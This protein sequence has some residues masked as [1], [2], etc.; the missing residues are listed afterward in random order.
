MSEAY[1]RGIPGAIVLMHEK[2]K[3]QLIESLEERLGL[4]GNYKR[5][6]DEKKK[7]LSSDV[8]E[9]D[10]W[11]KELGEKQLPILE[12]YD[13]G[14]CLKN[15]SK[16]FAFLAE[17]L[18][19]LRAS[20]ALNYAEIK[21]KIDKQSKVCLLPAFKHLNKEKDGIGPFNQFFGCM[22]FDVIQE[23]KDTFI[24]VLKEAKFEAA[25]ITSPEELASLAGQLFDSQVSRFLLEVYGKEA[26]DLKSFY[27]ADET[28]EHWK[29]LREAFVESCL[30]KKWAP[31]PVGPL[32]FS[33]SPTHHGA[34]PAAPA[35]PSPTQEKP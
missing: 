15:S 26:L 22:N 9:F 2:E 3:S 35:T 14:V 24:S 6:P 30:E 7:M 8:S 13:I 20:Y 19:D 21:K 28:G 16:P 5:L 31:L 18:Q 25:E 23:S 27:T 33:S 1:A 4:I 11:K 17:P 29:D 32:L 10:I 34:P 12:L